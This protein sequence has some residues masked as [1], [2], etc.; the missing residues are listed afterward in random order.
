M[1]YRL[2]ILYCIFYILSCGRSNLG[3]EEAM[4]KILIGLIAVLVLTTIIIFIYNYLNAEKLA[5]DFLDGLSEESAFV[6]HPQQHLIRE[7][8]EL[9][10]A[11]G[12]Y[13]KSTKMGFR[14]SSAIIGVK[15][16]AYEFSFNLKSSFLES[17]K[18]IMLI[19]GIEMINGYF[20]QQQ[21]VDESYLYMVQVDEEEVGISSPVDLQM[22]VGEVVRL[23]LMNGKVMAL[24]PLEHI[25]IDKVMFYD[26]YS[27][28]GELEGKFE[29]AE[30]Y[31]RYGV[32]E[33]LYIG[34]GNIDLYLKDHK[35]VA[36]AT[37][38]KFVPEFIRVLIND[39]G[40]KNIYHSH[41]T[42]YS[43]KSIVIRDL[44]GGEIRVPI[45]TKVEVKGHG[46]STI[47]HIGDNEY[48]FNHRIYIQSSDKIYLESV[49]RGATLDLSAGYRGS[50]EI[51]TNDSKTYLINELSLEEYLYGVVP[52]EMPLSFGLSALEI[53]SIAA[54]TYAVNN[55]YYSSYRNYS[56]HVVDSVLNQVYNNTHEN[57]LT[58]EAVDNT[59]GKVITHEG[60]VI[61]AKFFS[62]SSG[63][64]ANA[65][66]VWELRGN[67]PGPKIPYL[68]SKGQGLMS[69]YNIGNE[70]AFAA[71]I[72]GKD[73]QGFDSDSPFFRWT[74]SM[75]ELQI[76]ISIEENLKQRHQ[77]QPHSVLT[78][79]DGEFVSEEIPDKPLGRIKELVV[80]ERGEGG[81]IMI[82]DIVS[83]KGTYRI[84]KEYNIRFTLRPV[85]QD[86]PVEIL[87][88]DGS[89]LT[90]Y[91][92][93]PSAFIYFEHYKEG[94]ELKNIVIYGGGNGHGV[95]MSQ[96]GVVGMLK[97]GYAQDE[98][99]NHY[100]ENS[101]IR[102]LY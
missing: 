47:V 8:M 5:E 56:A 27:V 39:T 45:N 101:E 20:I 22:E 80:T 90:N 87:R 30:N 54:R 16:G 6:G 34:Q 61:D 98:I 86:E 11:Q 1:T 96:Y 7:L 64:S 60:Q 51:Y 92:I 18:R 13:V 89:V 32:E 19:E 29:F 88:K 35:V 24:S 82:L 72:K 42:L 41:L 2:I 59:T 38:E 33:G 74:I 70:Q 28:T 95:G 23:V 52:S 53:Q 26:Q 84:V 14:G 69:R 83:E 91:S 40:F 68:K 71:F 49:K 12:L 94:D 93:L 25:S 15:K 55:I 9:D 4:R 57:P 17:G 76:R 75:T 78:L 62:T 97:S 102:K 79:K 3:G 31:M 37:R 67:F 73:I 63:Y 65:N 10:I 50:F 66:E 81:N 44:E 77:A 36:L 85:S 43:P 48:T 100:Y 58:N 21:R 46:D 99:I